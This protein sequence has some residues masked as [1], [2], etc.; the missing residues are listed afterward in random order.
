MSQVTKL[1]IELEES[2]KFNFIFNVNRYFQ[3]LDK[4]NKTIAVPFYVTAKNLNFKCK[5]LYEGN[6]LEGGIKTFYCNQP[7]H[8]EQFAANGTKLV[9]CK[10]CPKLKLF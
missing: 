9:S 2:K 3:F 5:H 10:D 8:I 4:M 7:D 1:D 6:K